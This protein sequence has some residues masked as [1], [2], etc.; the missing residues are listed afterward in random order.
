MHIFRLTRAIAL[1]FAAAALVGCGAGLTLDSADSTTGL[2]DGQQDSGPTSDELT[3]PTVTFDDDTRATL[4]IENQS[5]CETYDCDW[6]SDNGDGT[7]VDVTD[8]RE[9]DTN[10]ECEYTVPGLDPFGGDV[11]VKIRYTISSATSPEANT[12]IDPSLD[13][14]IYYGRVENM[15]L[16]S[17]IAVGDLTGDGVPD[18]VAGP[19][20]GDTSVHRRVVA[21]RGGRDWFSANRDF[22]PFASLYDN[23]FNTFGRVIRIG[24]ITCDGVND[25]LISEHE[26]GPGPVHPGVIRVYE[27]QT[28]QAALELYLQNP[29]VA[30]T[31]TALADNLTDYKF[32]G[33][34]MDTWFGYAFDLVDG[35]GGCKDIVV[36]APEFTAVFGSEGRVFY[37]PTSTL[38]FGPENDVGADLSLYTGAI[39]GDRAGLYVENVGDVVMLNSSYTED[40]LHNTSVGLRFSDYDGADADWTTLNFTGNAS[41]PFSFRHLADNDF[42]ISR[43]D[44]AGGM[45]DMYRDYTLTSY[46]NEVA[47]GLYDD[48]GQSAAVG[49]FFP[50]TEGTEL[51]VGYH[52]DG[53]G[54]DEIRVY[55]DY[56]LGAGFNVV[57]DYTMRGYHGQNIHL[58]DVNDDGYLDMITYD[59]TADNP[60]TAAA[61]V[62]A[63]IVYY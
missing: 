1:I 8:D 16:G 29:A 32:R 5:E 28:I 59:S 15:G 46:Q 41:H 22:E 14:A 63:V 18:I 2:N 6:W 17:A 40:A 58:A 53:T 19:D 9:C 30:W 21:F 11:N 12:T 7:W 62:G 56:D 39:G 38:S 33:S 52:N 60:D 43:G 57:S 3:A 27:G 36:G 42:Y 37:I 44:L 31:E 51:L 20:G 48:F 49:D 23:E 35:A 25:L 54:E 45:V 4:V 10:G 34:D 13:E 47:S 26:D 24:D 61:N 50:G 55:Y